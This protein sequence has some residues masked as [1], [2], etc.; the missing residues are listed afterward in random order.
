MRCQADTAPSSRLSL[1]MNSDMGIAGTVAQR[2]SDSATTAQRMTYPK[3]ESLRNAETRNAERRHIR[4]TKKPPEKGRPP[5]GGE[6]AEVVVYQPR[7]V[8]LMHTQHKPSDSHYTHA[9]TDW[10]KSHV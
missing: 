2:K 6:E 8:G 1:W 3:D 5:P 4:K 7:G 9:T 10:R